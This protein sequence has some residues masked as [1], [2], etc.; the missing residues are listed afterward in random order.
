MKGFALIRA[1]NEVMSREKVEVTADEA[2]RAERARAFRGLFDD[3]ATFRRWYDRALSIVYPFVFARCGGDQTMAVEVTQEAFVEAVRHRD[4]FD[5]AADPVSWVCGIARHKIADHYRRLDR[6]RRRFLKL[7][8]REREAEPRLGEAVE[9]HQTIAV[10]LRALTP[11]QRAVLIMHYLD[12]MP[13]REIAASLERTEHA[14]ESLLTRA[15]ESFRRAYGHG[16]S[17][18]R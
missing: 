13:V 14:V 4:S 12:G 9:E 10:A 16:G 5:G 15:R 8:Y 3:Q 7:V 2:A 18:G 11:N 17:H 1:T 6:E